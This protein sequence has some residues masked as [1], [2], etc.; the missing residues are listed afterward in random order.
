MQF[1]VDGTNVG[2][3]DTTSPYSVNWDS[4]AAANG[5][6]A[7]TAVVRSAASATTTS[8]AVSVTVNNAAPTVTVT[9]PAA[10]ASVQGAAVALSATVT[11]TGVLGVQFKVDGANVGAEDTTS[12]Y[13]ATWDTTSL[14]N[15]S[16]SITAM[17]RTASTSLDSP[18]VAVNVNNPALGVTVTAP[19]AGA[20]VSGTTVPLTATTT[21]SGVSGVQFKVDGANVGAEDTTSPYS[22]ELGFHVGGRTVATTSPPPCAYERRRSVGQLGVSRG[23]RHQCAEGDGDGAGGW[24]D[25]SPAARCRCPRR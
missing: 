3:E 25:T 24:C 15:G 10:G 7:V 21:G 18:A 16:H 11:G 14:A 17:A 9:A 12:P 1:K 5:G 22:R 23:H 6:H 2:A 4:T 13:A 8:A 20:T 19:T